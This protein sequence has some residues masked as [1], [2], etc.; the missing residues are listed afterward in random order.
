M[1]QNSDTVTSLNQGK[2]WANIRS[3][4][5]E[6]SRDEG[7][8]GAKYETLDHGSSLN[9]KMPVDIRNKAGFSKY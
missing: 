4:L 3:L 9:Q 1:F 2:S 8:V 7:R 5:I 6:N